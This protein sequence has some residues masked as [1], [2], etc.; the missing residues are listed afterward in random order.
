MH[1]IALENVMYL[2]DIGD[3]DYGDI[4]IKDGLISFIRTKDNWDEVQEATTC[5]NLDQK[6]VIPGIID[7]HVHFSLD[8]GNITSIDD[9]KS[10]S[11]AAAFGGVTTFIDFLEPVDNAMDLQRAY[12]KR[13]AEAKDSVIDYKF[14]ATLKNPKG[15]IPQIVD[16]ILEL[17]ITSVK[18]F[19]TYSDTNRRTY[20][21]E[22]IELLKFSKVH[23]FTV[24]VHAEND[25]MIEKSFE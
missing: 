3:L 21:N 20:D 25:E 4:Y 11:I 24:L 23:H 19:T 8:L 6:L 1:D 9:F 15:N 13:L 2:N 10:G 22:I 12:N 18:V 16:K 14:H 5:Y 17:G 7:P